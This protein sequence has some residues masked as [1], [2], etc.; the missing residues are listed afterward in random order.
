[1]SLRKIAARDAKDD[2]NGFQALIIMGVWRQRKEFAH[3]FL[4]VF[5][6]RFVL[7]IA[8]RASAAE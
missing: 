8:V 6:Y 4:F 3:R 1:V 2:R 5:L 7:I